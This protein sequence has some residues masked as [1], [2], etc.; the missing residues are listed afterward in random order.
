MK[1]ARPQGHEKK[2]AS[3]VPWSNTPS[4]G[5]MVASAAWQ[6][7]GHSYGC[8]IFGGSLR[9]ARVRADHRYVSGTAAGIARS[10]SH[11]PVGD[12]WR[13]TSFA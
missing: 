13:A 9:L 6:K 8:C 5:F 11:H 12:L 2:A 4:Q 3:S 10:L 1:Q 7:H